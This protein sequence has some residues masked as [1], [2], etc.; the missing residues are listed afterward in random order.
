VVFADMHDAIFRDA[1]KA[2]AMA[3]I[4]TAL[5]IIFSYKQWR[6]RVSTLFILLVGVL[7]MTACLELL[8]I[9]L[10]F[11]NFLAFP[12]T[13]GLGVDYGVNIV[14]RYVQERNTPGDAVRRTIEATGG[15]VVL[16]SLTTI[17]GYVSLYASS[18]QAL[19]SFGAAMAISEVTCVLA[20]IVA[21]PAYVALRTKKSRAAE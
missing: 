10:N 21:L 7:W 20:A 4:L 5:L 6:D 17:H 8:D 11:L 12:I 13:I 15:A 3:F 18:N 19:N 16:C 9:K 14:Q 2:V 1:P